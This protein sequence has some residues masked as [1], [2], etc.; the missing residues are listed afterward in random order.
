MIDSRHAARDPARTRAWV[1]VDSDTI[2][3]NTASLSKLLS[4]QT[5]LMA[6]VKADGYGHGAVTVASEVVRH[7]ATWLGVAT[8]SEAIELRDAGIDAPILVFGAVR[9]RHDIRHLAHHRLCPTICD[10]DHGREV[11]D[12]LGSLE[13]PLDVH[14]KIDTGMSRLG[15]SASNALSFWETVTQLPQLTISGIYSHLATAESLDESTTWQ[16]YNRFIKALDR[17]P[18]LQHNVAVH[19]ANSAAALRFPRTHFDLVRVGLAIYGLSPVPLSSANVELTPVL[20]VKARVTQVKD[21]E[22]GAGISYGHQFRAS[23]GMR[24][25]TVAIGYADGVARGLSGRI[26]VLVNGTRARQVGAITMDQLMIDVTK[27]PSVQPGDIVTLIGR[28]QSEQIR[29][30]EWAAASD[31]IVWEVLCGFKNRLPRVTKDAPNANAASTGVTNGRFALLD[32]DR[33]HASSP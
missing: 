12:Q 16:Q 15:T 17:L 10:I 27:V 33:L 5:Q 31:T 19:L 2:A 14:L 23:H 11:S 29:A 6:V 25:G 24:V 26:D 21:V 13:R 1:E 7:G 4:P 9:D 22:R 3:S 8:V 30:E 32:R 28:D 18:R 20:Q